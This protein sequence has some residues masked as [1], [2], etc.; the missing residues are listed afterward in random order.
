MHEL[1]HHVQ[2]INGEPWENQC[3]SDIETPAH[4]VQSAYLKIELDEIAF[5]T[6]LEQ[7]ENDWMDLQSVKCKNK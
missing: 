1:Y 7:L 6:S 4:K 5:G 2:H 3:M